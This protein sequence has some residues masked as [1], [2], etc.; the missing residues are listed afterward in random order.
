MRDKAKEIVTSF[1]LRDEDS[2]KFDVVFE[3]I[4]D[5]FLIQRNTIFKRVRVISD[6]GIDIL[7]LTEIWYMCGLDL[8]LQYAA[9]KGYSITYA[10][11]HGHRGGITVK[12]GSI[13]IINSSTFVL[14]TITLPRKLIS[15]EL[16]VCFI[17]TKISKLIFHTIYHLSSINIMEIYF[18]ELI[19]LFEIIS[20]YSTDVIT[21]GEFNIHN[22]DTNN[23]VMK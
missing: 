2:K 21:P 14:C 3:Y 7:S 19:N 11:E 9:P 1:D 6:S 18:E 20:T 8:P 5:H 23:A 12:H 22:D 4:Y 16:L 15:F 17:S 10:P 13:A